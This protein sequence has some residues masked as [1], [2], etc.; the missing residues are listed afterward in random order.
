VDS[1]PLNGR[2]Y[3]DLALLVP[4]V[5]RTNTRSNERFAETSAVP[6]TGLSV[7]S[8]RNL[9]NTYIVDGLTANDDAADLAGTSFAEE[10][11]REFQ[12]VTSGATAEFGRASTGII[13]IVTKSGTNRFR[14]RGYGFF[15]NDRLDARNALATREDPLTQGQ[16]GLT[17]GG[18]VSADRTF[19]FGNVERTQQDKNGVVTIAPANVSG[20]NAALKRRDIPG[21][22]FR[23]AS[24][25]P[26]T[27]PPTCSVAWI[28]PSARPHVSS[29]DTASM[30]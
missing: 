23:P 10:V 7:S 30:T 5:S 2:N 29:F 15:R 21:H 6:G 1:L 19:W 26:A 22:R 24:S 11:V 9:G 27:T 12:V 17:L 4:N 28:T 14:G 20:I 8:Q 3:I 25:S 18:P 16:Y 13:N